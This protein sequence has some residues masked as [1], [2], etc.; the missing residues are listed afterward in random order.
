MKQPSK[1]ALTVMYLVCAVVGMALWALTYWLGWS[2]WIILPCAFLLG[3]CISSA[4]WRHVL[5][6]SRRPD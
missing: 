5:S 3:M 4:F 6:R 1:Y 2:M